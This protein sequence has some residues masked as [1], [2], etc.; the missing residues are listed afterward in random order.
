MNWSKL[1]LCFAL[2]FTA[3]FMSVQ[4]DTLK[5]SGIV[6]F[7]QSTNSVPSDG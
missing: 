1:L 2:L 3:S 6:T 4:S 5:T 7:S